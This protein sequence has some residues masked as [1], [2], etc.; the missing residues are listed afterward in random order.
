MKMGNETL[1]QNWAIGSNSSIIICSFGTSTSLLKVIF[2]NA[3]ERFSK[4]L[5]LCHWN[6]LKEIDR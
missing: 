4:Q 1:I 3:V 5:C 6:G 2:S